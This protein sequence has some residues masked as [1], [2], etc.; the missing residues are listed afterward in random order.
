MKTIVVLG[1][2]I[3][4]LCTMHYLQR[5]VL[6]KNIDV[7]L[8]LVEKNPYLGGKL[9]SAY[10]Q[11][12]IMETGADSIVARHKGVMELVQE[13][14]FEQELVYNE[15]GVSYIYTNDELHA[16]PADSTFGIPM[17]LASLEAST[18][19]S[20][21]GKQQAL[22]D[23]T[24]PNKGFTKDSSIGE[25]LTYYLGEEL[26]QNQIAPVLAGVYSGDL[27][28]LSIASTLPYIIDYKNE[29]GSIIKGFEANREQF[30]KASNKKFISFK[31]GL[32]S[33]IQRLEETLTNV[34]IIKGVAT[35]N[36]KKQE[37]HYTITLADGSMF[38]AEHVVLAL[39]NEAVQ[40]LLQDPSLDRYFKEF[41]TAS[42]ITIYLG[43]DVPDAVLP[44]DGTGFIV[45]HNSNVQCNAATWT[46][47]K[48][49]HTS[50]N[51]KLLVRLF[52]KSIN[53]AY[54]TLRMMTD[55]E[56]TAVALEDV[57][58]SLGIDE[59]PM[60]VNVAKWIDQMPKY[61]LA[62]HEALKGLTAELTER[63]PNLSIAGCSYF[64]VGIGACIQNGKKIGEALAEKLV[65]R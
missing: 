30:V 62:H 47:R 28:Q 9:H 23:L 37:E 39:P 21:A 42:A 48:W 24:M 1:G 12:F 20:E 40:S 35:T 25:F 17:S 58:K 34:E 6:Q 54:E 16:I 5:Q 64:G 51:S 44:A 4:G 19:V 52:Y 50:A 26:V 11:G 7:K 10:E 45:S 59:K 31:Q 14:N 43:F 57:K 53:P 38:E 46:S 63:Y 13:L 56:L 2:G 49:K 18:L 33:L 29:Y 41:T 61:D 3:T 15:T 22:Q 36:V 8:V 65:S 60:V 27:H 55:E 32:S